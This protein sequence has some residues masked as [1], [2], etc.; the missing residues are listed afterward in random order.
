MI[1]Y[2]VVS[3]I[4]V[5]LEPVHR[6]HVH[7]LH[8]I[9][10]RLDHVRDVLYTDLRKTEGRRGTNQK[11]R[12]Q[13]FVGFLVLPQHNNKTNDAAWNIYEVAGECGAAGGK[14]R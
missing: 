11:K 5:K 13:R 2:H 1:N 6:R 14:I 10:E 12:I 4:S 3:T 7:G 8:L 9:F